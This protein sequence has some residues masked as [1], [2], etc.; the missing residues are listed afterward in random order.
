[1]TRRR[2][3][4]L[5]YASG[6]PASADYTVTAEVLFNGGGDAI[7]GPG[8]RL[9][10]S[11]QTGY[12]GFLFNQASGVSDRFAIFKYVATTLTKVAGTGSTPTITSGVTYSCTLDVAGTTIALRV[13]RSSDS[14]WLNS[15]GSWQSGQTNCL[16]ATD[17][18]ITDAGRPGLWLSQVSASSSTIL[19]LYADE[20]GGGSSIAA[21][22][23]YRR[24]LARA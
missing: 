23:T 13:Q 5:W 22:S 10:T 8:A 16:S 4:G 9:S 2:F 1:V 3:K 21:I 24:M 14:N 7:A 19:R 17:S 12:F 20:A 11:A 15:S 18:S 6:T